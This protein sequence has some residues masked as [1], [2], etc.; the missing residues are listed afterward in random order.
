M[1]KLDTRLSKIAK[2]DFAKKIFGNLKKRNKK[3]KRGQPT[4]R[5]TKGASIGGSPVHMWA[6][7]TKVDDEKRMVYGKACTEGLDKQDE[8]VEWEATKKALGEYKQYRNLREMHK[9]DSAA[10]TV[11]VINEDDINKE[12]SIGAHVVDDGAW[13]KVKEGVYKGFSIGGK[14][15]NRVKEFSADLG[16]NI[17]R[18]KEF[19]LTEISL[20]DRP[21]NPDCMFTMIKRDNDFVDPLM[22]EINKSDNLNNKLRKH[23]LTEEKLSKLRDK[24]FGLVR[25]YSE[26][27]KN[28]VERMFPIPDKVHAKS[29][30]KSLSGASISDKEKALVHER[31]KK[32]LGGA[33]KESECPYCATVM[34]LAKSKG[35]EN[36][37]RISRIKK[38]I[39]SILS[40][41][42]GVEKP[43]SPKVEGEDLKDAPQEKTRSAGVDPLEGSKY[44]DVEGYEDEDLD[45]LSVEDLEGLLEELEGWEGDEG[46]AG[47]EGLDAEERRTHVFN[48]EGEVTS[49]KKSPDPED[50]EG[51]DDYDLEEEGY[52]PVGKSEVCPYC[53]TTYNLLAKGLTNKA[54]CPGC[55]TLYTADA[56]YHVSLNKRAP[57]GRSQKVRKVDGD[58]T[59]LI[60][61]LA[62][63]VGRL[64]KRT[65]DIEKSLSGAPAPRRGT[66]HLAKR[67][68]EGEEIAK[69][70]ERIQKAVA[71]R[72]QIQAE[73]REPTPAEEKVLEEALNESLNSKF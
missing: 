21:A 39:S 56:G 7:I 33:H 49:D 60:A 31:C 35:G 28:I 40:E 47:D 45:G 14:A 51:I 69:R 64:T 61:D 55:G 20:V 30:L 1:R 24:E 43:V 71:L 12:L 10:G 44:S 52:E 15:L 58:S 41:L 9:D 11:P 73:R 4:V 6:E 22:A 18:V 70:D 5:I 57:R 17:S 8:I 25:N 54:T 19:L 42:E 65:V 27:G 48:D 53:A 46:Y 66:P 50:S 3:A 59:D 72:K 2:G 67:E 36:M 29:V 34:S 37:N 13:K 68:D 63:A 26:G 16:K 23:V 62:L 38:S 32:V